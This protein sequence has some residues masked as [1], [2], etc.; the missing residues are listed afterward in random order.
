MR[1]FRALSSRHYG[2]QASLWL[3][4]FCET[5]LWILLPIELEGLCSTG[6]VHFALWDEHRAWPLSV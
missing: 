5:V 6:C 2:L 3:P 4:S 1:L